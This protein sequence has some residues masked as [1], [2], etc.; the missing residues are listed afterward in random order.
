MKKSTIIFIFIIFFIIILKTI[1]AADN[2]GQ[3]QINVVG[4][5][6]NYNFK[7]GWNFFSFCSELQETDIVTVLSSIAGKYRYLLQWNP[8][9]Q[10]YDLYSSSASVNPFTAFDDDKSYFIYMWEDAALEVA[11][12]ESGSESRNLVEGWTAPSYPYRITRTI[13]SIYS[14]I[15]SDLRY[16]MKWNNVNQEFDLY[17]TT[18]SVN[19]FNE[20]NKGEGKFVYMWNDRVLQY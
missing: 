5:D 14:S 11:G 15:I 3:I 4:D 17:S 2:S 13:T 1:N 20:I 18:A 6:C 9:N 16:I 12:A 19:P 8:V 7:E 10:E